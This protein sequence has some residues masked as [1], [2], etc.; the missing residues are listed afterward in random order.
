[1]YP[2]T[3]GAPQWIKTNENVAYSKENKR[4]SISNVRVCY[5]WEDAA[6]VSEG[7]RV[8]KLV[9]VCELVR[10]H[11]SGWVG[12]ELWEALSTSHSDYNKNDNS[13]GNSSEISNRSVC[14]V[15]KQF[16]YGLWVSKTI[17]CDLDDR[18]STAGK[19]R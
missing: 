14:S 13:Q 17:C 4:L 9:A 12:F 15:P 8:E 11:K 3:A 6:T 19:S 1:M 7:V 18:S 2:F 5:G 16:I 10:V